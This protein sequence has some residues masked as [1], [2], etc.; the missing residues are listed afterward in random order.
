MTIDAGTYR[1]LID[2]DFASFTYSR[3]LEEDDVESD[4]WGAQL[5]EPSKLQAAAPGAPKSFLTS[6]L[7]FH[8]VVLESASTASITCLP[9]WI[10]LLLLEELLEPVDEGAEEAC[11]SF[12]RSDGCSF[13]I[14]WVMWSSIFAKSQSV[15]Q[16]VEPVFSSIFTLELTFFI[17]LCKPLVL[18]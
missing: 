16:L 2:A 14:F 1:V 10:W 8:L 12:C 11:C 17:P 4:F 6:F 18:G 15:L 7:I 9:D 3:L 5:R 13:T